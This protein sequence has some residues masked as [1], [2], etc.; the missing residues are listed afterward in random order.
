MPRRAHARRP[1]KPRTRTASRA[2]TKLPKASE[3]QIHISVA[4]HLRY[5]ARKG[6]VWFHPANGEKRDKGAAARLK[7]MGVTPGIPD[8]VLIADGRTYG[9]EIKTDRGRVS[10]DQQDMLAAFNAAGAFTAV[11]YGI[12]SAL[13]ILDRWGLLASAQKRVAA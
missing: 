10:R 12:D 11:A 2:E 9:L 13:A 4:Q 7:A 8:L 5:R 6:V 1:S 3:T